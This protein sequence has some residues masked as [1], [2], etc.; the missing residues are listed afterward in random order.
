VAGLP[1]LFD[2]ERTVAARARTR[3]DEVVRRSRLAQAAVHGS[4]PQHTTARA[5]GLLALLEVDPPALERPEA[6]ALVDALAEELAAK[7]APAG[8]PEPSAEP[9]SAEAASAPATGFEATAMD[10]AAGTSEPESP[11]PPARFHTRFGGLL[12]LLVILDELELP[13]HATAD[14]RLETRPFRWTLHCLA[15]RL[16]PLAEDDPAALAFAGLDPAA[17]PPSRGAE[18]PAED[19]LAAID[20]L[21]DEVVDR[22]RA[23]L[24]AAG[25]LREDPVELVCRRR[26]E[27]VWDPGWIELRFALA[28]VFIPLRRAG[29]DLD[30]GYVPW[31]GCVVRFVYG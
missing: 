15:R 29:L 2:G 13:A 27:V 22:L 31:L 19:E 17:P 7:S 20:A 11:S 3:T 26:A 14:S 6:A 24:E 23:R 25:R 16:Q 30:P 28:D 12:F 4:R 5:L 9:A 18:P 21:R 1:R 10:A 8:H